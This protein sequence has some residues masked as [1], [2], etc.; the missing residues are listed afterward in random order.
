MVGGFE[1]LPAQLEGPRFSVAGEHAVHVKE[2][3]GWIRP[4]IVELASSSAAGALRGGGRL[5]IS[6]N[7][8]EAELGS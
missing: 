7:L 5:A 3:G 1:H 4:V 6:L 2:G 8:S